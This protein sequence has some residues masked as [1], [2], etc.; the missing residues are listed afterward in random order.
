MNTTP[1]QEWGAAARGRKGLMPKTERPPRRPLPLPLVLLLHAALALAV[2][3]I[4]DATEL[5]RPVVAQLAA[6]AGKA[7]DALASPK[8]SDDAPAA[9]GPPTGPSS[10]P[11]SPAGGTTAR[12]PR[13]VPRRRRRRT[14]RRRKGNR[15]GRGR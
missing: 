5:P 10:P 4:A 15:R 12:V 8:S 2:D 13:A 1:R 14:S 7:L 3:P 11:P 6:L 9:G